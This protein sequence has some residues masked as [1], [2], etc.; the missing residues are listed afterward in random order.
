MASLCGSSSNLLQHM[1]RQNA[2]YVVYV[3]GLVEL[4][5][6]AGMHFAG[7]PNLQFCIQF[8]GAGC[9]YTKPRNTLVSDRGI[10]GFAPRYS[11]DIDQ[12]KSLVGKN[13]GVSNQ[14]ESKYYLLPFGEQLIIFFK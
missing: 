4:L 1:M 8:K 3:D 5:F 11:L 9:L 2:L 12:N 14:L 6:D 13:K 7:N 10:F